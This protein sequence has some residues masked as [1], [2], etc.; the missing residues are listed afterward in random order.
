MNQWKHLYW[1]RII[2]FR[3]FSKLAFMDNTHLVGHVSILWKWKKILFFVPISKHFTRFYLQ[4]FQLP[5]R[6]V[7]FFWNCKYW[8][9]I[10]ICGCFF[11]FFLVFTSFD[12]IDFWQ[13]CCTVVLQGISMMIDVF[14]KKKKMDFIDRVLLTNCAFCDFESPLP[15]RT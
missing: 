11:L 14:C 2:F 6:G 12:L 1:P 4:T 15:N 8:K 9:K 3:S 13:V 7:G 5:F 10:Q